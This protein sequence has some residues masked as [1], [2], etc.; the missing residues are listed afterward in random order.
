[1]KTGN[2]FDDRKRL[3]VLK[4]AGVAPGATPAFGDVTRVDPSVKREAITSGQHLPIAMNFGPEGKLYI[5]S[6]SH[7]NLLSGPEHSNIC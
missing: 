3:Y 5:S 1:M 2:A 7:R 6:G 4:N